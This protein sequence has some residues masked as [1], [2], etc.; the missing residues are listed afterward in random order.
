M[1]GA[2]GGGGGGAANDNMELMKSKTATATLLNKRL[3]DEN[4]GCA[5]VL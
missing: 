3:I 2:E 4:R 1:S 5:R